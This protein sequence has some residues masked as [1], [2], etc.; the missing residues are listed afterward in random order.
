MVDPL[1]KEPKPIF[2]ELDY[3]V[4]GEDRWGRVSESYYLANYE[5]LDNRITYRQLHQQI[6]QGLELHPAASLRLIESR[7][8]YRYIED[9]CCVPEHRALPATDVQCQHILGT[10]LMYYS[11]IHMTE[12]KRS[13]ETDETE[14]ADLD[15]VDP[16]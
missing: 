1:F 11:Y 8:W 16:G 10:T 2:I 4:R 14:L 7:P 5:H 12:E 15:G 3:S 9:T 13:A 6:R